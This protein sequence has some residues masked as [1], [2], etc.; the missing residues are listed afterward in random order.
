MPI[1]ATK[2]GARVVVTG[3]GIVSSIGIGRDVFWSALLSGRTGIKPVSTFDTSCYS[4]HLGGEIHG[5]DASPFIQRV[6]RDT[7]GRTSQL[8]IAAGRLAVD[9]G[10]AWGCVASP[11][12][13][14]LMGTTSG[15]PGEIE[16]F[17]D[18]LLSR[19]DTG[20]SRRL[21]SRYPCHV[22]AASMARE[23]QITGDAVVLPAACAAGNYAI[24]NAFDSIQL[25]RCDIALAGGA[26][27]FSRITF[28]GF[29]RLGA[30]A[31]SR[32]RPFDR[33][34]DGMIPGE[35]AAVLLIESLDH[36]RRRGA[37]VLAEI[38]GYGLTCDAH[39]M[40]A[41]HP[42]GLGAA[43]AMRQA[44]AHAGI[45]P[46]EVSYISAHGTGTKT[47]DRLESLAVRSVFS[48][49]N[50]PPMSSVKALLGH[51]M[52]AASALEAA[53]CTLAVHTDY[54]PGT[55]NLENVDPDC[56]GLD[57]IPNTARSMRVRVA[58]NNAYAFGG[59]NS[60]LIISK[61]EDSAR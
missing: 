1:R 17:N 36:A 25:N 15:E 52:G 18:S 11:R 20:V 48:D 26:D 10:D 33:D 32:C 56:G 6:D 61:A 7:L 24:A 50:G 46:A 29:H 55:L 37:R 14:V 27:S 53:V 28:T 31:A 19:R 13:Q 43:N 44:L 22:I 5:F 4:V 42:E 60:S 45:S 9:D 23:F 49:G 41:A 8:A 34:R 35:A 3:L 30:I 12:C 58:M 16:A 51:T 59:T 40:T 2:P 47:N 38:C 39:H 57:F 54:V 21:L